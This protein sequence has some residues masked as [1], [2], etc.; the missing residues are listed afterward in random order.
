MDGLATEKGFRAH[1]CCGYHAADN[2][3]AGNRA[4]G[5]RAG[6]NRAG[7]NRAAGGPSA[8][9]PVRWPCLVNANNGHD[10]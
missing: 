8:G 2:Q 4:A 7:G 3:A 9:D 5:N 10:S 6:G 1:T